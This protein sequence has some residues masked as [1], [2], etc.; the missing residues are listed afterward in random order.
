MGR[1]HS[2]TKRVNWGILKGEKGCRGKR[3]H[4]GKTGHDGRD[5]VLSFAYATNN[6]EQFQVLAN[7]A[8]D[9]ND[10]YFPYLEAN[11][12][13]NTLTVDEQGVYEF[14]YSVR[15]ISSNIGNSVLFGL[16]NNGN[17]ING[18]LNSLVSFSNNPLVLNG[19]VITEVD[20]CYANIQLVNLSQL[21]SLLYINTDNS[22]N[23]MISAKRLA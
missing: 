9:F 7:T 18:S 19:S 14:V 20:N 15:G 3:G 17:V 6:L 4:R 23:A 10:V 11:I 22:N 2:I 1:R 21:D 13:G 12:N 5:A 16:T 8:V